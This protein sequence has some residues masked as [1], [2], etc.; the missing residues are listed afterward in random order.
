MAC[1][2]KRA[3]FGLGQVTFLN[4]EEAAKATSTNAGNYS[5]SG[6]IS[7]IRAG[8][9]VDTRTII[10]TT[11]TLAPNITYTIT[12]T[13][14]GP[15]PAASVSVVDVLPAGA[16]FG[17]ASG[18]GWTCTNVAGTVTCTLPTLNV[19]PANPITLTMSPPNVSSPSTFGEFGTVSSAT[20][21]TNPANNTSTYTVPLLPNRHAVFELPAAGGS[22]VI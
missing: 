21:D 2:Q 7:V 8:F 18:T 13:N 19:G 1:D 11:T 3:K 15:S 5:I 17:S 6:G 12:V 9:G 10:L 14:N 20:T 22:E 4:D 16:T